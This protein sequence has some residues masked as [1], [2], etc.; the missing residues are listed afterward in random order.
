MLK[1]SP[2]WRL[3]NNC[4]SCQKLPKIQGVSGHPSKKKTSPELR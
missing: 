1:F 2:T 4:H 3:P